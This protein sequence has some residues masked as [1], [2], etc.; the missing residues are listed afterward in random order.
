MTD[1][2]AVDTDS[3]GISDGVEVNAQ[4]GDPPQA[5]D[6]RNNNT[7]GDQFD[8][9][10][11]DINGNGIVDSNETDP[12]RIEDVGDFDNDGIDNREENLTCTKW[13]VADTDGGGVNVEMNSPLVTKQIHV[14]VK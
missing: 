10:E 12:T 3:D 1:P 8:D 4:Y 13:D 9:G 5:S 7:D 14:L 11:E 2:T 6:P